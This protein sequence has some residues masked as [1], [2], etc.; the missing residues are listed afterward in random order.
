MSLERLCSCSL[1]GCGGGCCVG[2]W[3]E[4]GVLV[5]STTLTNADLFDGGDSGLIY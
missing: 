5:G 3:E 2:G 1:T 4:V